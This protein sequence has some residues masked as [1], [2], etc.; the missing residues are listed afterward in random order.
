M[1]TRAGTSAS[2]GP[3]AARPRGSRVAVRCP[4][5]LKSCTIAA[6]RSVSSI[7]SR[8]SAAVKATGVPD[9]PLPPMFIVDPD[10]AVLNLLPA[11]LKEER[12]MGPLSQFEGFVGADRAHA[13]QDV[14][15]L[16]W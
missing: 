13:L 14:A 4:A 2:Q 7:S 11:R 8:I 6:T 12:P 16:C 9:T 10:A 15:V 5:R 3:C 1:L